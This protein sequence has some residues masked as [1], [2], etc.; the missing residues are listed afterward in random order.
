LS[1]SDTTGFVDVELVHPGGMPAGLVNWLCRDPC[2]K[3]LSSLRDDIVGR[4]KS[5]GGATLTAG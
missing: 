2:G 3:M 4:F 5:G 1:G